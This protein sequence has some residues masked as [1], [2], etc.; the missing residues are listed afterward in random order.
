[1]ALCSAKNQFNLPSAILG[2]F[3]TF[4]SNLT[5]WASVRSCDLPT[6]EF[7]VTGWELVCPC[8][9][10]T[11]EPNVANWASVR[12]WNLSAF[13][14]EIFD[15][16]RQSLFESNFPWYSIET[17]LQHGIQSKLLLVFFG[18]LSLNIHWTSGSK[19]PFI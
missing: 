1:M 7:N 19:K 14:M 13:S 17:D 18:W 8:D 5:N 10:P 15:F 11:F 6:F 12:P 16:P 2:S 4:E 9:L 3:A